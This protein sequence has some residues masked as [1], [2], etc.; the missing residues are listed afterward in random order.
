MST[1]PAKRKEKLFHGW[2][3]ET[4]MDRERRAGE[5]KAAAAAEQ[6]AAVAATAAAEAEAAGPAGKEALRAAAARA[7]EEKRAAMEREAIAFAIETVAARPQE[8]WPHPQR[9]K[10]PW[11][12]EDERVGA[13]ASEQKAEFR[14]ARAAALKQ[15]PPGKE[16][17]LA[18]RLFFARN[19]TL[20]S[21]TTADAS[22][23]VYRSRIRAQETRRALAHPRE[24]LEEERGATCALERLEDVGVDAKGC[25]TGVGA[26]VTPPLRSLLRKLLHEER[27]QAEAALA[28]RRA[29]AIAA[30][31][32][33]EA[34]DATVTATPQKVVLGGEPL[35]MDATADVEGL[36]LF[37]A[38][39]R[40][41]TSI[42]TLKLRGAALRP[43]DFSLLA[44]GLMV[45]GTVELLDVS[46]NSAQVGHCCCCCCC[47]CCFRISLLPVRH[48]LH[49]LNHRLQQLTSALNTLPRAAQLSRCSTASRRIARSRPDWLTSRGCSWR[50]AR[51]GGERRR[52]ASGHGGGATTTRLRHRRARSLRSTLRRTTS[53]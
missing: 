7:Y 40:R 51:R 4:R 47:C 8:P 39:L 25:A 13:M 18:R 19:A 14:A 33:V 45:N 53:M 31:V 52:N 26:T 20:P 3:A 1:Q 37:A 29:A 30:G 34:I 17:I 11:S 38:L 10:K 6:A 2:K 43:A 44:A 15:L 23:E 32:D 5:L 41:D 49:M 21:N 50:T 27:Q 42:V 12:M 35:G 46:N 9:G 36:C 24:A 48:P 22:R 28:S 16:E